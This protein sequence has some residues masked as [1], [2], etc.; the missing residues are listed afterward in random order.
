MFPRIEA[1]KKKSRCEI[2]QSIDVWYARIRH[3]QITSGTSWR[4]GALPDVKMRSFRLATLLAVLVSGTV[5]SGCANFLPPRIK[6]RSA[7][8]LKSAIEVEFHL[9]T[10]EFDRLDR[11]G[12]LK[13][14]APVR[15]AVARFAVYQVV[16]EKRGTSMAQV[17]RFITRARAAIAHAEEQMQQNRCVDRD[18]DGLTDIAERRRYLTDPGNADTD[19]DNVPDG[20]EVRRHRTNPLKADTDGDMLDDG[21]EISR[22]S[23]PL[24]A[25][26]DG[27][28]F[29]DGVEAASGTD[30][31]DACSHPR[32]D[33]YPENP[34][35]CER[36][37]TSVE[38]NLV[39]TPRAAPGTKQIPQ[40]NERVGTPIPKKK[41]DRAEKHN[42]MDFAEP[43]AHAPT[44]DLAET[45]KKQ[46]NRP[47]THP[48]Y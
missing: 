22:N 34:S 2:Q 16:I 17:A 30:A 33:R 41:A 21:E 13:L 14:C 11:K 37:K 5:L 31:R 38:R 1:K 26:S 8:I 9:L 46:N 47:G 6:A 40:I 15:F 35:E 48:I 12:D 3:L 24:L 7:N 20:A 19:G 45:T 23:N 44:S 29:N 10:D 32:S 42:K 18:G 28:G 39:R 25:D 43:P 27:D 36:K 4:D